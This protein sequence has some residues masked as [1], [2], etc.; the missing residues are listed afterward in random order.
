M[1]STKTHYLAHVLL[2]SGINQVRRVS[3]GDSDDGSRDDLARRMHVE[4]DD[5][6]VSHIDAEEDG[7][8]NR[9]EVG[10]D[11]RDEHRKEDGELRMA[12]RHSVVVVA[13]GTGADGRVTC[14]T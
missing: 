14:V 10:V 8:R 13:V 4:D 1:V 6:R 2:F 11:E 9:G 5:S 3:L 7:R 12:A